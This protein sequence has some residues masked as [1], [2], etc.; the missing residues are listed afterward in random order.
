MGIED[1][2]LL[3][4]DHV[5]H[6]S[7]ITEDRV[8]A[9][10]AA[11]ADAT[12]FGLHLVNVLDDD[13]LA[14]EGI[15]ENASLYESDDLD[16]LV[17]SL[18]GSIAIDITGLEHRVWAPM[19]A[20]F[21]RT[22]TNLLVLYAEPQ[23]YNRSDELPGNVYDL[24]TTKGIAPLPGFARLSRRGARGHFVPLLG[25][26]GARLEHILDQE[27]VDIPQTTPVIGSPGF[28]IEYPMY[29]YL[30]NHSMLSLDHMERRVELARA[31]CP[32]EAF[33]ALERIHAQLGGNLRV[34]PIGTKPHSLG[35]ILYALK[36]PTTT[37]LIYDN[38]KRSKGRTTGAGSF[39]AYEIS[40]YLR[41]RDL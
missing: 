26:E 8:S 23:D 28:R 5:L 9:A 27:D 29:T 19:V 18:S 11:L 14:V 30:A 16:H 4:V 24:S 10:L 7:S 1:V 17:Q 37:E 34:A 33:E 22:D 36:N 40:N 31:S 13:T 41:Y 15:T 2:A 20:A 39:Y 32:F 35:A 3:D 6:G 38:P 21:V 25:F 12:T